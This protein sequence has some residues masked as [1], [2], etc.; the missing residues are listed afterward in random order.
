MAWSETEPGQWSSDS[1]LLLENRPGIGP[2]VYSEELEDEIPDSGLPL[3]DF[4]KNPLLSVVTVDPDTGKLPVSLMPPIAITDL[5]PVNSQ[6]E[7]LGLSA[8]KGDLAIRNDLPGAPA[9]IL[10]G[11]DSTYL[12]NWKEIT[13]RYI[14]WN[15]IQGVPS[16]F[17]PADHNHNLLYY[18]KSEIDSALS[19]K[20][21]T[22]NIPAIEITEDTNHRFATDTEKTKWNTSADWPNIQNKPTAFP[23]TNHNHNTDY[24]TKPELDSALSQKRNTGNIPATDVIEDSFHRFVTDAQ[25]ATW[26]SGGSSAG[27][28]DVGDVKTSARNTPPTGWLQANGQTIGNLSSGANRVGAE[29]Q[30][31]YILLWN[32]WSNTVLPIQNSTGSATV[33]G[34]SAIADWDA[35]KRLPIPNMAGRTAIGSGTGTG[36]TPR[37]VGETFGEEAHTLTLPEIPNHDHGGG[38]HNHQIYRANFTMSGG[39]ISIAV[40]YSSTSTTGT[41]NSAAI[42]QAQGAGLPHNNIQ[43]SL[44]LNYFIKY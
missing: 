40:G 12:G 11:D 3:A 25:I 41:R 22:G 1:G 2:Y 9:F 36:L 24:Y 16:Q 4:F 23:P 27:G 44:V 21:N 8:Q 6:A 7:M 15:H 17:P 42:I 31:L 19:Q 38:V 37:A 5:F 43:P 34:V 35:G 30:N 20:R 26:N 10:T 32:D 28:F 14:S 18:L 33:R 13:V 29:Y 39:G